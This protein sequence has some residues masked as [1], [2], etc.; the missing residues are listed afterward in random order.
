MKILEKE[1]GFSNSYSTVGWNSART[2]PACPASPA[3]VACVQPSPSRLPGAPRLSTHTRPNKRTSDPLSTR[4][5]INPLPTWYRVH[6]QTGFFPPSNPA[7]IFVIWLRFLEEIDWSPPRSWVHRIF[8]YKERAPRANF[9]PT[10]AAIA[11]Q[12]A[13]MNHQIKRSRGRSTTRRRTASHHRHCRSR[14]RSQN[15]TGGRLHHRH[16]LAK[17]RRHLQHPVGRFLPRRWANRSPLVT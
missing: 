14:S 3:R 17:P 7:P 1:K 5:I 11:T 2:G 9:D 10:L 15:S 13:Q 16:S 4:P 8:P 6:L 12:A